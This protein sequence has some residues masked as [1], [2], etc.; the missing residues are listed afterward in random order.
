MGWRGSME[1]EPFRPGCIAPEG[2]FDFGGCFQSYEVLF[3]A[4]Q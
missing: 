4:G 3:G 1:G 2:W